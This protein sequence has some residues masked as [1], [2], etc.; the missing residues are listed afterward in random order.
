MGSDS[1]TNLSLLSDSEVVALKYLVEALGWMPS[2]PLLLE[3]IRS[4]S[5]Q[6]YE[7]IDSRKLQELAANHEFGK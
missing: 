2:D 7:E 3:A 6:M 5:S 1:V 4:L